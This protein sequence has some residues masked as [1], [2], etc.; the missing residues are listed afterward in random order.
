V[1]IP[2]VEVETPIP[3]APISAR[4]PYTESKGPN[5][6]SS[7]TQA[8]KGKVAATPPASKKERKVMSKKPSRVK[9]NDPAPNPSP[10]LTPPSRTWGW[11]H[12]ALVK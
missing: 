8:G 11:I 7:R 2:G 3:V 1:L 5:A 10:A 12:H 9:I 4:T 6:R